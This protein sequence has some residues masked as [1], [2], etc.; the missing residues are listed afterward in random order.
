MLTGNHKWRIP[1]SFVERFVLF[2]QI[3]FLFVLIAH[4]SLFSENMEKFSALLCAIIISARDAWDRFVY[5]LNEIK[6]E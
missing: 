6:Y 3:L 4:Y 1:D 2:I 5:Y